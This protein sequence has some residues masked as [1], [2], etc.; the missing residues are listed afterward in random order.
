MSMPNG[1]PVLPSP[2][3]TAPGVWRVCKN[4][5]SNHD[6]ELRLRVGDIVTGVKELGNDWCLGKNE[7]S[8]GTKVGIFP[9]S[10][11]SILTSLRE[12]S[13]DDDEDPPDG[14]TERVIRPSPPGGLRSTTEPTYLL[15][16]SSPAD[17]HSKDLKEGRGKT[18][19]LCPLP[20]LAEVNDTFVLS[21]R[22]ADNRKKTGTNVSSGGTRSGRPEP[23]IDLT[24]GDVEYS[25]L[26]TPK[27]ERFSTGGQKPHLIVKPNQDKSSSILSS[28]S[29]A[30]AGASISGGDHVGDDRS[31]DGGHVV[32]DRRGVSHVSDDGRTSIL[33]ASPRRRRKPC[34]PAPVPNDHPRP[35]K[36]PHGG[37]AVDGTG[38][39]WSTNVHVRSP[40]TFS[41][42]PELPELPLETFDQY[43]SMRDRYPHDETFL[44]DSGFYPSDNSN[45]YFNDHRF[46]GDPLSVS[47]DQNCDSLGEQRRAPVVD[48][49]FYQTKQALLEERFGMTG[50][51]QNSIQETHRYLNDENECEWVGRDKCH[52]NILTTNLSS[53]DDH[54]CPPTLKTR[55]RK[56][57]FVEFHE[58][59]DYGSRTLTGGGDGK[60]CRFVA[61]LAASIVVGL[62]LLLWMISHLD[63]D[64]TIALVTSSVVALLLCMFMFVSRVIRCLM[65]L[66]L[67]SLATSRGHMAFAIFIGGYLLSGPI[68]NVYVNMEEVGVG[69]VGNIEEVCIYILI[70]IIMILIPESSVGMGGIWSRE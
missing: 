49:R 62:L 16:R 25:S 9:A 6:G 7:S 21:G 20:P 66:M 45:T 52:S 15:P 37:V 27:R 58:Q 68:S 17:A 38:G 2:S 5:V 18:K 35:H 70:Q 33:D 67:P 32:D 41:P 34:L 51:R 28:S 47:F 48:P 44:T 29:S 63:Y 4:F 65:A 57:R 13:E 59:P 56:H 1:F 12:T 46:F 61:S 10:Y 24:S 31:R 11:I 54:H 53:Y 42:L 55:P 60:P 30:A 43:S 69:W 3:S 23:D 50:P 19:H 36:E 39:A 14:W 22:A 8:D 40:R 26:P 64:V